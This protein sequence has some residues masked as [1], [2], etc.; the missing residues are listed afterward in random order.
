MSWKKFLYIYETDI[1]APGVNFCLGD[2]KIETFNDERE[3]NVASNIQRVAP[4]GR[5]TTLSHSAVFK[6]DTTHTTLLLTARTKETNIFEARKKCV[7]ILDSAVTLVGNI[8]HPTIF[9]KRI[10]VGWDYSDPSLVI[11][12]TTVFLTDT[13]HKL[14]S[15][16][17][18]D[19]TRR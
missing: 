3:F 7:E 15:K 13:V 19:T 14:D 8:Y 11:A 4:L 10:Y 1:V 2:V 18:A 6:N 5:K 17:I 16:V 12:E 9:D